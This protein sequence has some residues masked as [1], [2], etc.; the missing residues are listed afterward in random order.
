MMAVTEE[1]GGAAVR[2]KPYASSFDWSDWTVESGRLIA[3]GSM[4]A[5]AVALWSVHG[6]F[7]QG[8]AALCVVETALMCLPWRLPRVDRGPLSFWAES[9]VGLL[10]PLGATVL[11]VAAREPWLSQGAAWWWYPLGALTGALLLLLSRVDLRAAVNGELAFVMGPTPRSH[12]AARAFAT[13][14][15][16]VG[17]EA[18]FRGS[19]LL[20]GTGTP[21][22]VL[23]AV[24]FAARH[25]V[26]P[27]TNRRG[28]TRATLVEL[29]AAAALLALTLAS[30]SVYPGLL[31]H[32]L[33]NVPGVVTELQREHDDR[34]RGTR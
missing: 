20:A 11:A 30:G 5:F 32:L 15:G 29:A 18:M 22:A 19:V 17:E 7:V 4:T 24:A 34:D 13:A 27:G 12:G 26:A 25:H 28:T 16:P 21:F 9:L 2:A 1:R 23:G 6:L 31:A 3:V 33:N 10:T 14:M 8:V